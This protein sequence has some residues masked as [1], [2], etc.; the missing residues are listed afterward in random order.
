MMAISVFTIGALA[1]TS[2]TFA[3]TRMIGGGSR[4]NRAAFAAA[5]AMERLRTKALGPTG[6]AAM[7]N[8][9]DTTGIYIRSWTVT[10]ATHV[11][12]VLL[13]VK[14]RWDSRYARADTFATSVSC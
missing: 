10:P 14:Y 13:I 8:G 6:C 7:Q 11:N 2:S 1:L 3:L 4:S 9:G 5:Q 12:R